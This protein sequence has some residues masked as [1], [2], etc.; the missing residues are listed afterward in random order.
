[1]G[2][3]IGHSAYQTVAWSLGITLPWNLARPGPV[4]M[5]PALPHGMRRRLLPRVPAGSALGAHRSLRYTRHALRRRTRPLWAAI[6]DVLAFRSGS[7]A[8][9]VSSSLCVSAVSAWW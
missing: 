6:V 9:G 2:D 3:A 8:R 5:G 1:M 7:E 4:S